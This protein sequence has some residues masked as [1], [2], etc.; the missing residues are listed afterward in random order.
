MFVLI[1]VVKN[2]LRI[3]LLFVSLGFWNLDRVGF[4]IFC[5]MYVYVFIEFMLFFRYE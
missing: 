3:D 4:S 1:K 5:E 2:V